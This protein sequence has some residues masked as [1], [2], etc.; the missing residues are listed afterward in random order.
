MATV[1]AHAP[2]AAPWTQQSWDDGR[3]GALSFHTLLGMPRGHIVQG[4]FRVKWG[5]LLQGR[6]RV[7][8][9]LLPSAVEPGG[10]RTL[11][12]QVPQRLGCRAAGPGLTALLPQLRPPDRVLCQ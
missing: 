3:R 10:R 1:H 4:S 12:L 11:A 8:L 7:E 6:Q 9:Q 2:L 5:V